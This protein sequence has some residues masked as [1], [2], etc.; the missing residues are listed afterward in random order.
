M[1][2]L[3]FLVRRRTVANVLSMGL[4][5][6]GHAKRRRDEHPFLAWFW[7]D[8]RD[9]QASILGCISGFL[10]QNKAA[11]TDALINEES[12]GHTCPAGAGFKRALSASHCRL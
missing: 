4:D 2:S 6:A 5:G 1:Q 12:L 10:F 9:C 11:G 8:E 3:A 7:L